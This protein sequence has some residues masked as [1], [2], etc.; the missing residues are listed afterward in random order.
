MSTELEKTEPAWT[1]IEVP[2]RSDLEYE[3]AATLQLN[4]LASAWLSQRG[5]IEERSSEGLREFVTRLV[6]SWV[7]ETGIIERLYDLD[8][9]VTEMLIEHGFRAD[10]LNR[11]HSDVASADL[12]AM[13]QDH[14]AAAEMVRD[15]VGQGRP[16]SKHFIR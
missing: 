1:P 2:D 10:L 11:G 8:A 7:I 16:L 3:S 4:S 9:G 12:L 14:V 15:I 6:R 13:L 5:R